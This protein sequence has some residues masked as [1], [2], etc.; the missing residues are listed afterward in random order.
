MRGEITT[1]ILTQVKKKNTKNKKHTKQP[2]LIA[3]NSPTQTHTT[4]HTHT[5]VK[6]NSVNF[7]LFNL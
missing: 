2:C 3:K 7:L 5:N 6:E 1:T 4:T